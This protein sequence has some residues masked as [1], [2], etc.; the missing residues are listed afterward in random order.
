LHTTQRAALDLQIFG[1]L[2]EFHY[3][4]NPKAPPILVR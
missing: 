2:G 4:P 1:R 3:K